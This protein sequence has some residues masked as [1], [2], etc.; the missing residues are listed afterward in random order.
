MLVKHQL[1]KCLLVR[2][3]KGVLQLHQLIDHLSAVKRH[4]LIKC[5]LVR[6]LEGV[7]Q[8]DQ[9]I[10]QFYAGEASADQMP[11]GEMCGVYYNHIS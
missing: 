3:V 9:L 8:Q 7:L 11:D 1:I 5:L 4:H 10:Y 2:G 6:G